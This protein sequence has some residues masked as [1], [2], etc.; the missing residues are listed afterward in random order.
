[1]EGIA[2]KLKLFFSGTRTRMP[3]GTSIP[4]RRYKKVNAPFGEDRKPYFCSLNLS[5]SG[6]LLTPQPYFPQPTFLIATR[7]WG[8]GRNG[9]QS[10]NFQMKFTE[11][12]KKEYGLSSINR[13]LTFTSLTKTRRTVVFVLG[14]IAVSNWYSEKS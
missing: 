8:H 5:S 14:A 7:R 11:M 2:A 9:N 1:M 13:S 4:V 3:V 12:H 10:S 6:F